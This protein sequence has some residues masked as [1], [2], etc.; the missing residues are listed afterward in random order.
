[1]IN[2]THIFIIVSFISLLSCNELEELPYPE[3][4]LT[5]AEAFS[6]GA[7]AN[8]SSFVIDGKAY[9]L[10]G[11]PEIYETETFKDCWSFNSESNSWV[12]KA[13]FP[14]VG[15][16]GAIA[17]VVN[18][19][20]FVGFGYRGD[21][22]GIYSSDSTILYD[23][24]M[25]NSLLD[26]WERKADFPRTAYD[27]KPP[28]NSCSSFT[29]Q[30]WIYIVGLYNGK[31]YSKEVWR[32]DSENDK[33]ERMNDFKGDARTSAVAC[34]DGI[35]YFFGM[36]YN[37]N[38]YSDWWQYFPETDT[39]KEMKSIPGK[40]RVNAVS[41]TVDNRFFVAGGH[42]ISGTLTGN[43]Y[44]DDILEYDRAANKWYRIG[45]IP[46]GGRENALTFVINHKAYLAFGESQNVI[47]D[48]LWCFTP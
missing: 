24:W 36:G 25:Y 31:T 44:F 11:R 15:R 38:Y 34:T 48:D 20:A 28:L 21:G 42:Y 10:F 26:S 1:M 41:F 9:I 12:R 23:F 30:K 29:Y 2:K 33:W 13:D 39:W 32:Y 5:K 46:T 35:F 45:K 43:K 8:A 27:N 19:K 4:V 17:E 18:G 6:I 47:Y 40:G 14:G 16:V 22:S 3:I 7:R 37:R